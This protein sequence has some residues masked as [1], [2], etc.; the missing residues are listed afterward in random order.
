MKNVKIGFYY[1]KYVKNNIKK[2]ISFLDSNTFVKAN[3]FFTKN[4]NYIVQ[5]IRK[6]DDYI[7]KTTTAEKRNQLNIPEEFK[8][9]Q[10]I[11]KNGEF[12]SV[13]L[14]NNIIYAEPLVQEK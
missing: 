8:T 9:V 7:I 3:G 10:Q 12:T 6:K 11:R 4:K 2:E 1:P 14:I 5:T 13:C